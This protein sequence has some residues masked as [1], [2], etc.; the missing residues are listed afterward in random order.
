M[1]KQ[2]PRLAESVENAC[3]FRAQEQGQAVL[4]SPG[5][6]PHHMKTFSKSSSDMIQMS[7]LPGGHHSSL[8]H[9]TFP[10]SFMF[11]WTT[12]A[13]QSRLAPPLAALAP[14]LA[15][16]K[17]NTSRIVSV[18]LALATLKEKLNETWLFEVD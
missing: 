6:V 2:W 15:A 13:V 9:Q 10:S 4:E 18:S 7:F 3:V 12:H 5:Q 14:P 16:S 1:Y 8:K 11:R 17:C